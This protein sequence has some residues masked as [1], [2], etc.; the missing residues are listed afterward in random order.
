MYRWRT[1]FD[2][3]YHNLIQLHRY[4]IKALHNHSLSFCNILLKL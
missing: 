2:T 1:A 3:P 4:K